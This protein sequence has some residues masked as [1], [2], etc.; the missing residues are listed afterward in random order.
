MS[1][2]ATSSNFQSIFD[3]AL[4]DYA[5]QTGIDLATHPFAQTLQ[6]CNSVDAIL[7]LL[8]EKASQFQEYRDGN[9]KLIN[10]LKPVVGVLHTVASILGE[11]AILVS[12]ANQPVL[13]NRV[14]ITLFLGSIPTYHG[15]P[16][17][18]RCPSCRAYS[19]HFWSYRC[20]IRA[21]QASIGISASYDALVELF[22]RIGNFLSRFKIYNEIPLSVSMSGLISKIMAEVLS[23]L[24][25]ATKQ[26]KEGRLSMWSSCIILCAL[27][28]MSHQRNLRRSYYSGRAR[29]RMCFIGW[30]AS[31]TKR[32]A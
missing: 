26:I 12:L 18:T 14:F 23:V 29:S 3:A 15:N 7:A 22:E 1:S 9:R 8:Q 13:S 4:A 20:N 19:P 31:R 28:M 30:T 6:T 5:K 16:R 11:A 2:T 21:V 24:S 17:W 27:I 10:S 25:L 32:L